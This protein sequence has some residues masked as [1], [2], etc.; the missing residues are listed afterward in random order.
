VLLVRVAAY[1]AFSSRLCRAFCLFSRPCFSES[2]SPITVFAFLSF[3]AF[4]PQNFLRLV[5]FSLR[6]FP[7]PMLQVCPAYAL[8]ASRLLAG[9]HT[10]APC[11]RE[12]HPPPMRRTKAAS[13][14]TAPCG[15]AAQAQRKPHPCAADAARTRQGCKTCA[16]LTLRASQTDAPPTRTAR[17]LSASRAFA[18][19]LARYCF[20]AYRCSVVRCLDGQVPQPLRACSAAG[21]LHSLSAI[22][23]ISIPSNAKSA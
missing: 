19:L 5:V 8:P 23:R 11:G 15:R 12:A 16:P 4:T 9:S 22:P 13:R 18:R 1:S 17:S 20:F 3:P 21:K 10:H 7:P 2:L 14:P 6:R